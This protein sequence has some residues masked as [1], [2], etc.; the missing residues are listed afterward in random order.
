MHI[1][2]AWSLYMDHFLTI[3][4]ICCTIVFPLQIASF[5]FSSNNFL[6]FGSNWGAVVS[7]TI[8]QLFIL[9]IMQIPFISLAS[10]V[11][12]YQ[13]F[14]IK[15]IYSKFVM[16]LVPVCIMNVYY[17]ISVLG[18]TVLFVIPGIFMVILAF[19]FPY[20]SIIEDENGMDLFKRTYR[21]GRSGFIDM[22]VIMFIFLCLNLL[23]WSLSSNGILWFNLETNFITFILLRLTINGLILPFFIFVV[24]LNYFDWQEDAETDMKRSVIREESG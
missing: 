24:T 15:G 11:C 21:I 6:L 22:I 20:V 9:N 2:E 7:G 17:I 10:K 18:G 23:V 5:T 16:M 4:L 1:K 13:E 14:K 12:T 8:I 19:I 3:L